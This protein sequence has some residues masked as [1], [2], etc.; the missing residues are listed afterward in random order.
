LWRIA[1]RYTA[2]VPKTPEPREDPRA[3]WTGALRILAACMAVALVISLTGAARNW[4]EAGMWFLETLVGVAVGIAVGRL[5]VPRAWFTTRLWL[6][7][8]V[9]A[10]GIS[11]P[12][13]VLV[14]AMLVFVRHVRFD[15]HL[16]EDALP[17]VFGATAVMTGLAFLVR[18][19]M[20]QTHAA[21]TGAPPPKFLG[22]LPA[23]LRGA[24][25]YA[26]EAEDHYLRLHTSLGQD[27]IL[28][29]LAD[30]IV[31]LE[32]LEGAQ[33]HRSWWVARDA[34]TAAERMDGR[35]VLTLMDGA[36]APVSRGFAKTLREAGWF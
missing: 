31:E 26:V 36:E 30:A 8:F 24:D 11:L 19:S 3:F 33:T 22:R 7:G 13:S 20:T 27:L 6:A 28:M 4:A 9:V 15:L 29:R 10:A 14:I 21:A 1:S 17:S 34:V 23:R 5:L 12:M 35:A 16:L 32:G 18:R 2:F 25:L